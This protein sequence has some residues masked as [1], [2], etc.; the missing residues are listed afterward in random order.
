MYNP[1]VTY[2]IN[3]CLFDV[4][5]NLGNIWSEETYENALEIAFNEVGFQ[6]R[7]QVEFDVYY[8]NYRVGVYR[9]DLIMDDMLIIELKALPQIFPVNKA[10]I[11][12]YLKGTKKP[13]GLLVNFGQE[14]K[15][16]F[17][18]FP[19]KVTAKCLDIHFDKEKTNIQEQLPLLLLE[20]S[21]AVLEYLG[22]GYF[23]QVYQRAM[24]YELRML[25]TPYQKIFKIEAN[26]RGQLVGAKEVR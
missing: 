15:V 8:Y 11:I 22:P 7:R 24:N 14:R 1:E 17:Q 19:N 9:M 18:Y 21:K 5:N 3:K 2:K 25:D 26:F 20:K 13:I 4:Y 23:H 6:C 12:S 10:Q 16:F